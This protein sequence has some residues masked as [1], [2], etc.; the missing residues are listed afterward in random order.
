MVVDNKHLPLSVICIYHYLLL[1]STTN[2]AVVYY[3]L[4]TLLTFCRGYANSLPCLVICIPV[5][6]NVLNNR[7]L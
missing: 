1:F 5:L 7:Y 4:T 2:A 3:S 6:F